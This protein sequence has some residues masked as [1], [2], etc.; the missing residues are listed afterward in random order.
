MLQIWRW[1]QTGSVIKFTLRYLRPL[2][3]RVQQCGRLIANEIKTNAKKQNM[4]IWGTNFQIGD[5]TCRGHGGLKWNAVWSSVAFIAVG[6]AIVSILPL[7]EANSHFMVCLAKPLK[8]R[9][10]WNDIQQSGH[11]VLKALRYQLEGRGFEVKWGERIFFNLANPS[12]R[13]RP[14]G[15]LS[16]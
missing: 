1:K 7:Q 15:L 10:F 4:R 12:G 14:W 9:T 6:D 3:P 2:L 16:L 8:Q 11:G 13:T 5:E